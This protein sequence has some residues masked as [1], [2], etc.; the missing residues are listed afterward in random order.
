MGRYDKVKL[1]PLGEYIP[2]STIFGKLIQR[3]SPLKEQLL[4]G[5]RPLVLPTP[6]GPAAVIMCY[7]SAFPELLR[8]QILQGGEFILSSANNAHYS[9][10]MA[11]QHH[12]LDV[13]RAIEGDRW[14]GRATNTGLSAMINPRGKTLWL[15]SMNEYQIHAG[16]IYPRQNLTPYIL[17][18]DW[19]V[20][21]LLVL[22]TIAWVWQVR[23]IGSY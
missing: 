11:A 15:S 21:L 19:F 10:T 12:A 3:L 20:V 4:P 23:H 5:D 7:E 22:A 17:W 16:A 6:F 2:L 9:D 1:V 18:G 14:L 8:S 13:M